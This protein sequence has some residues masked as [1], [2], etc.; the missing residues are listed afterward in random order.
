V[1][2]S[3]VAHHLQEAQP[4]QP[5]HG[6]R[7]CRFSRSCRRQ[8]RL[9]HVRMPSCPSL[10]LSFRDQCIHDATPPCWHIAMIPNWC[11]CQHPSHFCGHGFLGP[12]CS[13]PTVARLLTGPESMKMWSNF[14]CLSWLTNAE[15]STASQLLGYFCGRSWTW[16]TEAL[17]NLIAV[18]GFA[19]FVHG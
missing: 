4:Q 12:F 8:T 15:C 7:F 3:Q 9:T 17:V 10:T 2:R 5:Q 16:D 11:R 19:A 6:W 14:Y 1:V 18:S 13:V